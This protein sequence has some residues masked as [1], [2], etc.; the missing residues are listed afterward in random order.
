MT[1]VVLFNQARKYRVFYFM[2]VLQFRYMPMH[3]IFKSAA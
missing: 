1:T 2:P 3:L